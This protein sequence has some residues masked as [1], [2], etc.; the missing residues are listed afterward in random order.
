MKRPKKI[1]NDPRQATEEM[2]EGLVLAYDGK[3]G[4]VDGHGAFFPH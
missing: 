2:M 1:L 3:I 4:R